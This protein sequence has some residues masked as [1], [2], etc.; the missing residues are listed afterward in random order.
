MAAVITGGTVERLAPEIWERTYGAAFRAVFQSTNP[1]DTPLTERMTSRGLLFP[2]PYLLEPE[3]FAA[4]VRAAQAVGDDRLC[5]SVTEEFDGLAGTRAEHYLASYW[6]AAEYQELGEVGVL[7]N[8]IYSPSGQW[9]LIVSHE[10]HAV[11]GGS[12]LFLD[13]LASHFPDFDSSLEQF[14]QTWAEY[15]QRRKADTSWLEALLTHVY[16]RERARVEMSRYPLG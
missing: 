8:A 4:V 1:F 3:Q 7:E 12:R 5:I 6:E 15:R 10:Q 16:G 9:G 11:A 14:L 13:A 2:V